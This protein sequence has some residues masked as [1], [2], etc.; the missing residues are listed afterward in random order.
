MLSSVDGWLGFLFTGLLQAQYQDQI[1]QHDAALLG[2][3]L[4]LY[5]EQETTL[6]SQLTKSADA[7]SLQAGLSALNLYNYTPAEAVHAAPLFG[8]FTVLCFLLSALVSCVCLYKIYQKIHRIT[9]YLHQAAKGET[10]SPLLEAEEGSFGYLANESTKVVHSLYRKASQSDEDK[11]AL[12]RAISD[13]SHQIKT[14]ITSMTMLTDILLEQPVPE[15][16]RVLFLQRIQAQL[17]RIKWLVDALLKLSKLDSGSVV[18]EKKTISCETLLE[19]CMLPLYPILQQR[20]ITY[21]PSGQLNTCFVGD[22]S[23]MTEAVGNVIKNCIEHTP[24]HGKLYIQASGNPLYT[25]YVR[26]GCSPIGMKKRFP[27]CLSGFIAV[28]TLRRTAWASALR[29]RVPSSNSKTA[30]LMFPAHLKRAAVF[31]FACIM[32]WSNMT[33]LSSAPSPC[34]HPKSVLYTSE[35]AKTL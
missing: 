27:I 17:G 14:P 18:M 26:G 24:P 1:L 8:L 32:V 29:C 25:G 19:Q 7:S 31:P 34:R 35:G 10:P 4:Q 6:V 9:Q 11:A 33:N 13:I 30:S 23:W 16:Q 3:L 2:I 20:Q 15:A 5:P 21:L 12:S 28:K 22:L